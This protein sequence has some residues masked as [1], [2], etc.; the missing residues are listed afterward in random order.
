MSEGRD[1][2]Q[3]RQALA[4]LERS[5]RKPLNVVLQARG[6]VISASLSETAKACG[7]PNCH[8]AVGE[9]HAVYQLS[10]TEDGRRRSAHVSAAELIEL[11]PAVEQYRGL[12]RARAE[13]VRLSDQAL[14]LIDSLTEALSEPPPKAG[15]SEKPGAGERRRGG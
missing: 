12:R 6:R 8:C 10:W 3:L 4:R 9:K 7:R 2:A 11:R 1:P 14:S 15:K 5:R 13:I